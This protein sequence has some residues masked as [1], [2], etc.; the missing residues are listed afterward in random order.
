MIL[1]AEMSLPDG[2]IML[3]WEN[4]EIPK[5]TGIYIALSYGPE[6][7][8]GNNNYNSVDD[9]GN[10][11]EIQ[12]AIMLHTIEIDLMSFSA[13]ARLRKEAVL[14]ALNSYEAQQLMEQ[15]QMRVAW[16]SGAFVPVTSLEETKQ[17]NRFRLT[18]M[19]NALH[20]NVKTTPFYDSLQTVEL[21]ENP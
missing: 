20:R 9:D 10:Y 1:Q 3:G 21:T 5:N 11:S 6:Q 17:L 15:Y 14:W 19:V 16:I 8:V 4:F 2:Q 18:I 12:D 7:V 13:E